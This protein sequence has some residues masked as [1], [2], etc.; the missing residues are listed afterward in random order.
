MQ[1]RIN[2][3]N[4]AGQVYTGARYTLVMGTSTGSGT[5]PAT[6]LLAHE[7]PAGVTTA[8]L[9]VWV[10]ANDAP[11]GQATFIWTLDLGAMDPVTE[12]SGVQGRLRGLGYH[13]AEIDGEDT[14]TCRTAVR[15]FQRSQNIR[16]DGGAGS[17]T[18]QYLT[19][20][21]GS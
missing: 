14:L 5:V 21:Y 2:L 10:P 9:R 3:R 16:V 17:T 1:L 19:Q 18:Q 4:A 8:E 6:G 7:I 12:L 11:L 13:H 20:A 15:G